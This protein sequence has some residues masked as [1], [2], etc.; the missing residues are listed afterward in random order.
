MAGPQVIAI[1]RVQDFLFFRAEY[2]PLPPLVDAVKKPTPNELPI[3]I[4]T[5]KTNTP[6]KIT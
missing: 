5:R 4:P 2:S 1:A 6:P 3:Q